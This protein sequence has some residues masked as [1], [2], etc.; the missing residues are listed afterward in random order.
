MADIGQF[1]PRVR[2]RACC[3]SASTITCNCWTPVAAIVREGKSGSIPNH[4]RPILER[5]GI[6]SEMWSA[7]VSGY[8]QMFGHVVGSFAEVSRRAAAAGERRQRGQSA[9][10]A[11]FLS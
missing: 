2:I 7:V 11:V 9:C 8:E 6:R 10:A 5:L 4:V 3:R 1:P